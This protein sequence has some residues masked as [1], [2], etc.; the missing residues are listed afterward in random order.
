MLESGLRPHWRSQ[1]SMGCRSGPAMA[2]M[3]AR[4]GAVGAGAR[5]RRGR[6]R[7]AKAYLGWR[8]P[9]TSCTVPIL[10]RG[11]PRRSARPGKSTRGCPRS[12]RRSTVPA[13]PECP[14]GIRSCSGGRGELLLAANGVDRVAAEACFRAAI[15]IAQAQSARSLGAPRHDQPRSA[16]GGA[17][18]TPAGPRPARTNLRLVHRGLCHR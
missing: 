15:D 2:T 4:V 8:G 13:S 9:A 16:I 17:G 12:T 5:R 6:R 18:P 14:I 11:W 10:S 7:S 3:Y 1:L